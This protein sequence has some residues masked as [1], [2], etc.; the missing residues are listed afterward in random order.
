MARESTHQLALASVAPT[1]DAELRWRMSCG[2][3]LPK[4][5]AATLILSFSARHEMGADVA[6]AVAAACTY[7]IDA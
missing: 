5:G 3:P 2:D 1:E 6:V 4:V 7:C